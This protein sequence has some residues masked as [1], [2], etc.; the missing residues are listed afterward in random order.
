MLADS[1]A[2]ASGAWTYEDS[3]LVLAATDGGVA[4][5]WQ[6]VLEPGELTY[7]WKRGDQLMVW[8]PES[9]V[10]SQLREYLGVE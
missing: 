3:T 6:I 8:V 1:R 4:E 2:D 7:L 10:A 5:L 9:L